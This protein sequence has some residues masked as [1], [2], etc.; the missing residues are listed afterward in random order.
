MAWIFRVFSIY[1]VVAESRF[2][3]PLWSWRWTAPVQHRCRPR[4]RGRRRRGRFDDHRIA[5]P[6]GAPRRGSHSYLVA[7]RAVRS[8]TVGTPA[9]IAVIADAIT[10][11]ADGVR[12]RADKDKAG[13]STCSA[14]LA[15]SQKEARQ[16][17]LPPRR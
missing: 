4:A 3:L 12:F 7:Q 15:R 16:G 13:R 5:S 8:G 6:F 11:R 2:S 1:H 9:F 17:G 14:K 10:H